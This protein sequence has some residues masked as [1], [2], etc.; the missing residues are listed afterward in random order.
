MKVTWTDALIAIIPITTGYVAAASCPVSNADDKPRKGDP[1]RPPSAVFSV[2]WPILYITFGISWAIANNQNKLNNI[3]YSLLTSLLVAWVIAYG[4]AQ[5][6]EA[7]LYILIASLA[8]SIASCV[9]GNTVSR[10]LIAPLIAWLAFA[11]CLQLNG[12]KR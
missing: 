8:A 7:A 3:P 5:K 2:V 9:V 11:M 1:F 10:I 6:K 4:C 12:M